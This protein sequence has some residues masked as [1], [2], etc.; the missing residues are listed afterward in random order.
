MV[1]VTDLLEVRS[2]LEE[3]RVIFN[4]TTQP[5]GRSGQARETLE[6][7][8]ARLDEIIESQRRPIWKT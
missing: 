8:I 7:A 4:T 5:S 6:K 2:L 1:N 3:T